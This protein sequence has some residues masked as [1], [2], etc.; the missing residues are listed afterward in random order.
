MISAPPTKVYL[1]CGSKPFMRYPAV[2]GAFY[3]S[4]AKGLRR[5]V[6]QCLSDA[7]L[8]V[9]KK[10]RLAIVCPH[11]GYV[12]SGKTAAFSFAACSNWGKKGITAV[13]IGPNHTGMG[14]PISVSFEDWET[15]LGMVECDSELADGIVKRSKIAKKDEI[16]HINEHSVE[17]QLPFLQVVCPSAR[18]V[19][20]CMGVQDKAAAEDLGRA[21]FEAANALGRDAVVVASSDFTHYES[22]EDAKKKD[23]AAIDFL[24][25]M[26]W[27]SFEKK[28]D[29]EDLSI[30]GH[31]P[32][33]AAM[34]YAK[35]SGAKSCELLK[36]TNSGEASGDF[37]Q[38]VAYAALAISR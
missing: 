2:S 34:H 4:D 19:A 21:I 36:Y 24:R 18:F 35:L 13:I 38:V 9:E 16:A 8:Q 25:R 23:G 14:T 11:A 37:E 26:D 33:A 20:V 10:E 12:Y 15:P 32:I 7:A 29:S 5:E 30:C 27:E 1:V 22:A 3:A 31:G 28:M 17:V 6:A